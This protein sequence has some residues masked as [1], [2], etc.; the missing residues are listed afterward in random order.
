MAVR[1]ARTRSGRRA[2]A[3]RRPPS[4]A[5][6]TRPRLDAPYARQRLFASLDALRDRAVV[7]IAGP[8]GA[9]KT[10]VAATWIE[11]RAHPGIWYQL[12]GGD[13]DPATFFYYLR[14]AAEASGDT[15]RVSLPLLR[16]EDA[17][18]LPAF[19]RRWFRELFSFL[20]GGSV[21][22]LDNYQELADGSR[23]HAALAA[24]SEEIPRG[25][26]LL[27]MSRTDPPPEFSRAALQGRLERVDPELLRLTPEEA[28]GIA[29]GRDGLGPTQV[30]E[31]HALC[32][33][34]AAG[35]TLLRERMRRTGLANGMDEHASMQEVF[36]Y[37]MAEVFRA[38]PA[39]RRDALARTALL[40]RFTEA[41]A[42][43]LIGDPAIASL[44]EYLY[45]RHLFVERR[46]GTEVTY[47]YHPLFRAFLLDEA[48]RRH[49][50]ATLAEL[51]RGAAALLARAGATEDA[52][53]L[54][55]DAGHRDDAAEL[56]EQLAP[57]LVVTGRGA[58]LRE[59]FTKLG[60]P[61]R[62]ARPWL[63]YWL[64]T[65]LMGVETASA[66]S[67]Y[68]EA[69]AAFVRD[70]NRTGQLMAVAGV[71]Q[72]F[73]QAMD[74]DLSHLPRW[75]AMVEPLVADEP[76][77]PS[78][79]LAARVYGTL[80]GV[81][82]W[83]APAH[84]ALPACVDRLETLL[85]GP[86]DDD[87]KVTAAGLLAEHYGMA[88]LVR[89]G[90]R[91]AAA[92]EALARAPSTSSFALT[93]WL[94]RTCRCDHAAGRFEIVRAKLEQAL[95]IAIEHGR[96]P[97]GFSACMLL[98]ELA[99]DT[100]DPDAAPGLIDRAPA[101]F[102]AYNDSVPTGRVR[103]AR[104]AW[105]RGLHAALTG[106]LEEA[107]RRLEHAA[108]LTTDLLVA[109]K[110]GYLVALAAVLVARGEL[111][112]AQSVLDAC[113]P[114]YPPERY[115]YQ[116][117]RCEGLG[118]VL[119]ER[120]GDTRPLAP[121][122]ESLRRLQELGVVIPVMREEPAAQLVA[123]LL[124]RHRIELPYARA[125]IRRANLRP[126]S[127]GIP[128]WPWRVRVRTLG[129]FRVEVNDVPLTFPGT[130]PRKALQ[131]LQAVV[132]FGS[133][134]V[135]VDAVCEALWPESEGDAAEAALRVTLFRLRGLLG[136]GSILLT[137]G[138]LSVDRRCCWVDLWTFRDAC[139]H[140]EG[141]PAHEAAE[142]LLDLYRGPFLGGE[143]E[144]AWMLPARERSRREFVAAVTAIGR[145][146]E[147]EGRG[148]EASALRRAAEDREPALV[149]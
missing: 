37:F 33:G 65:S 75:L 32:R 128:D 103:A 102:P 24:A 49:A 147:Q 59:A 135:P 105:V 117:F 18:D 50:P 81:M 11:T 12:D 121:L 104:L 140:V 85:A 101:V 120:R 95:A 99:M 137:Q 83:F 72:S 92:T 87:V 66:R 93:Y 63:S 76:A 21:L 56:L 16:P 130:G 43:E 77:F 96:G 67:A 26:Q 47:Q 113:R 23:L 51:S 60:G 139:R 31:L 42:I 144:Q 40:P 94:I 142:L 6:L 112:R 62:G 145:R 58:A 116:A 14:R 91:V 4:L 15:A 98:A 20:P 48:R 148:A 29:A 118:A 146:L 143:R 78:A 122:R 5:K 90:E 1:R 138:K 107:V 53:L 68:E 88:G 132:A 89:E 46:Y 30:R 25:S 61:A 127:P 3:T 123:E 35:F 22:A 9:G 71:L 86:L 133:E 64:A 38:L 55:L 115:P 69:H 141:H 45:R 84:A 136:Y 39:E 97:G 41:M 13:A 73:L 125:W 7:W 110:F 79:A 34:W 134:D 27:V 149:R 129:D 2:A 17:H 57:G 111:D 28:T 52:L 114:M 44:L 100:G 80:V 8:P 124:V 126:S 106:D 131:L 70:R 54:F 10:T 36:D 19:A 74:D 82:C 119:A 108:S 109:P